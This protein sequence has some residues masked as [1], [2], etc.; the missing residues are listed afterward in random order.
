MRAEW[1][2]VASEQVV[3]ES[4]N[5]AEDRSG[6][7]V[8]PAVD[9]GARAATTLRLGFSHGDVVETDLLERTLAT[10]DLVGDEIRLVLRPFQVLTLRIACR[11]DGSAPRANGVCSCSQPV[12]SSSP[13]RP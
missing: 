1:L 8:V 13:C 9:L 12:R 2:P 7:V 10:A 6:D 11:R 5:L 3:V 4:V